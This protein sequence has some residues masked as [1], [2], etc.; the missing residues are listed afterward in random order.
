[1]SS[2]LNLVSK[3]VYNLRICILKFS[4]HHYLHLCFNL[5][6][7]CNSNFLIFKSYFLIH[8]FLVASFAN[9]LP[10]LLCYFLCRSYVLYLQ[11]GVRLA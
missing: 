4:F 3:F 9:L 1:M 10:L 11:S 8:G 5:M 7:I 6:F 2:K